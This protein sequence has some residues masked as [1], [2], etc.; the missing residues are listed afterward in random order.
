[1]PSVLGG[2]F[3][4]LPWHTARVRPPPNDPRITS[5]D[6]GF[7]RF[8]A[9][10]GVRRSGS[11]TA[12][13]EPLLW[14]T[15]W[16]IFGP[17]RLSPAYCPQTA[18]GVRIGAGEGDSVGDATICGVPSEWEDV[19]GSVPRA[20]PWAGMRCS[21]GAGIAQGSRHRRVR[22]GGRGR[23]RQSRSAARAGVRGMG[24]RSAA[25]KMPEKPVA[26]PHPTARIR[27]TAAPKPTL[28]ASEAK[29]C[30]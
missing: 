21:L 14:V 27:L 13:N 4:T 19:R 11:G 2:Q 24:E 28:L 9:S 5:N 10:T 25:S 16:V 15:M 22:H 17:F 29:E 26:R 1:M 23:E 12:H 6:A 3:A 30:A 18:S 7:R 8:V 20:L